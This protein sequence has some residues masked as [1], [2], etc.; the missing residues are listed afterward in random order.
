[1]NYE[2]VPRDLKEMCLISTSD[3]L[4]T[5]L[6]SF[7]SLVMCFRPMASQLLSKFGRF[8]MTK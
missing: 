1:M 2:T 8:G 6:K 3:R 4:E 5:R 7:L